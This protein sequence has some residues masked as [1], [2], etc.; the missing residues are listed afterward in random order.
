MPSCDL[1]RPSDIPD[2]VYTHINFASASIDPESLKIVPSY[3][4]DP[5]VY[6]RLARKKQIDRY[7]KVFISIGGPV[8]NPSDATGL[9]LSKI[10][11]AEENQK[12]FIR[13][14]LSFMAT[15]DFD[16][17]DIDWRYPNAQQDFENLPKFLHILNGALKKTHRNG[18]SIALP[19]LE[20]QLRHFDIANISKHVDHINFMTYDLHDAS[21]SLESWPGSFVKSHTNLTDIQN[22]LDLLWRENVDPK[23]I[24]MGLSFHART[25]T[26]SDPECG[27]AGCP[28][29]SGGPS[30]SCTQTVGLM[31]NSEV[32][33]YTRSHKEVEFDKSAAVKVIKDHREWLTYDDD[34]TWKLKLIYALDHCIGGVMV[35]SISDDMSNGNFSRQLQ[36]ATGYHSKAVDTYTIKEDVPGGDFR[37]VIVS[38][39]KKIYI[40]GCKGAWYGKPCPISRPEVNQNRPSEAGKYNITN[41]QANRKGLIS[42]ITDKLKYNGKFQGDSSVAHSKSM[43]EPFCVSGVTH[44]T[45]PG[46]TCDS[47]ALKYSVAS[48][49]ILYGNPDILFC[50]DM[51]ENV[52]ICLPLQCST[53][54]LQPEDNCLLMFAK[55]GFSPET[56]RQYNPWLDPICAN[57]Q[58]ASLTYGNVFCISHPGGKYEHNIV[59]KEPAAKQIEYAEKAVEPP[60]DA[61]LAEGTVQSCGRW[62][63]VQ[64]GQDCARVLV[65]NHIS[66]DLF[67]ESNPSVARNNCTGTLVPGLTYCVGPTLDA[68]RPEPTIPKHYKF[69]CYSRQLGT[70]K[71]SVLILEERT[72]PKLMSVTACM[73]YC[74]SLRW[75]VFGLQNGDTCLCDARLRMG[76]HL[77]DD[78]ECDMNCNGNGETGCGGKNAVQVYSYYE[79]LRLEDESS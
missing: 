30:Q 73:A 65:P 63:T 40:Y 57:I 78:S 32:S 16:G 41:Q 60:P 24:N 79:D 72:H 25:F 38:E 9:A 47:L 34:D 29:D 64:K 48:A 77:L 58:T 3:S 13:S 5:E 10:A 6:L 76:S 12:V 66:L 51:V 15:Y 8:D 35:S 43:E 28:F 59:N 62:H 67:I 74:L 71:P 68:F 1:P 23:K 21:D 27:H 22:A 37:E 19:A 55:T 45:K 42:S 4:K 54:E 36:S 56:I 70:T 61:A 75:A 44:V 39:A 46:D 49:S 7:L 52:P 14:L 53:Y 17:V 31:S 20:H 11:A 33:K 69:G 18:L 50:D 2:G 26:L